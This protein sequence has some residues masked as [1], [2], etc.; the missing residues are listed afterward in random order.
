[1]LY[2]EQEGNFSIRFIV[3]AY[4]EGFRAFHGTD[5]DQHLRSLMR[6]VVHHGHE[7]KPGASK[8]LTEVAEAFTDCQA[9]Q[10]RTVESVGLRIKG[11]S[12]D[13]YGHLVQLVSEYKA[14]AIKI[15]AVEECTKL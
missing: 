13:F 7:G 6:L 10:A 11:V 3:G 1:M 4:S 9:V 14:M 8:Y 15:L 2:C 5:L 12:L